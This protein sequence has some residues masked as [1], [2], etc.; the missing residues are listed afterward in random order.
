MEAAVLAEWYKDK[1]IQEI[2]KLRENKRSSLDTSNLQQDEITEL[3]KDLEKNKQANREL[4][5]ALDNSKSLYD[6][7]ISEIVFLRGQ[8][9]KMLTKTFDGNKDKETKQVYAKFMLNELYEENLYVSINF[10][11]SGGF[12]VFRFRRSLLK[13]GVSFKYVLLS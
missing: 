10:L 1:L 11:N 3:K 7:A 5:T 13:Y 6:Q 9:E 12:G 4:Q 2:L 8:N